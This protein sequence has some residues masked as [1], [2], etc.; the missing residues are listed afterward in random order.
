MIYVDKW[1][2]RIGLTY[3]PTPEQCREAGYELSI[4]KPQEVLDVEKAIDEQRLRERA[5][6]LAL[7]ISLRE[8][9]K[10]YINLFCTTAGIAVV[11]KFEDATTIVTEIEKA[12]LAN[13]TAKA[14]RLTQIALSV[15]NLITELRRKDGDDAWERIV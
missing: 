8:E 14:L 6:H 10:Q 2:D 13:D 3:S 15:Q 9:Y 12:N 7:V 11:D 5:E 1:P 4:N